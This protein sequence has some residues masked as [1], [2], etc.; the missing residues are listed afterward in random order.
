MD[1]SGVPV[2]LNGHKDTVYSAAFSPDG[3]R[4]VTASDDRTAAI[5]AISGG[6]PQM[7]LRGHMAAIRSAA[8]DR[9]GTQVITA[10]EDGTARVWRIGSDQEPLVLGGHVL[11]F[12]PP[13]S[14]PMGSAQRRRMRV[15]SFGCGASIARRILC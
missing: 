7:M 15:A 5:W 12:A 1:G 4:V 3:T 11:M 9:T 8:F 13:P 2:V 6:A 14:V 10:S